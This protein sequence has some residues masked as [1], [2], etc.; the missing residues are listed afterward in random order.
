MDAR[1]DYAR[2]PADMRVHFC[3]LGRPQVRVVFD[4]REKRRADRLM[5]LVWEYAS[6]S[7]AELGAP[8]PRNQIMPQDRW[9]EV[10][11]PVADVLW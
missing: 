10:K 4:L 7:I 6:R 5:Q 3:P 2:A 1:R 9:A 8:P 11:M